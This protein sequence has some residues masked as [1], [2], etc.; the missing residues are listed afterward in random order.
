MLIVAGSAPTTFVSTRGPSSN[1]TYDITYGSWALNGGTMFWW[2]TVNVWMVPRP[3]ATK[4]SMVSVRHF[5]QMARGLCWTSPHDVHRCSTISP[6]PAPSH[7]PR[8]SHDAYGVGCWNSAAS[9]MG[10]SPDNSDAP[11]P[12]T[13]IRR[14]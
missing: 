6:R 14:P 12:G 1:S 2:V 5:T 13:S 10:G 11:L 3:D 4:C 9:V 8:V 7:Q